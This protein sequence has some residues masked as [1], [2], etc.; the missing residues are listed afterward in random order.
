MVVVVTVARTVQD[1]HHVTRKG[2]NGVRNWRRRSARQTRETWIHR[3]SPRCSSEC[4]RE[5]D[6]VVFGGSVLTIDILNAVADGGLGVDLD[7][8]IRDLA[9][10]SQRPK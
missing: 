9:R 10:H 7:R 4:R 3:G 6:K 1:A 2:K 5:G 8:R